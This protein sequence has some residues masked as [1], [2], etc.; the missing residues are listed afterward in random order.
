MSF[1]Q[2]QKFHLF[3]I[4]LD[5][6]PAEDVEMKDGKSSPETETECESPPP[7]YIPGQALVAAV[8]D[9]LSEFYKP[10]GTTNLMPAFNSNV[11]QIPRSSVH[12]S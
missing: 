2:F 11:S 9:W 1:L 8:T 3:Q 5:N 12:K 6:P 4:F 10:K 7:G